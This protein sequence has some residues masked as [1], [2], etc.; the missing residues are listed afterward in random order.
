MRCTICKFKQRSYEYR[1]I[2]T[3][4]LAKIW[5]LVP[6]EI[7]GFNRRE[8]SFCHRC[9]SSLRSR[10]LAEAIMQSYPESKVKYFVD[11]VEW[12]KTKRLTIA[13]INYCGHLHQYLSKI[14]GIKTSQY[15]ESTWRAR[16]ANILKGIGSEDMT[17][18]SYKS[19]SFDLVLHS[20]VVEHIND[21]KKALAECK[22]ILIPGGICLFTT[23]LIIN[24]K[25][26]R[27]AV[28]DEKMKTI[29]YYGTPSYH[30][31]GEEDNLVF[32]EFGGDFIRKNKLKV[33]LAYPEDYTWVL[34]IEK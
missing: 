32:W 17:D 28:I 7:R 24:R 30:G 31:S 22:R 12:A 11:W 1:D 33:A 20:E 25:T 15:R 3:T 26:K 14:P 10:A 5:K 21:T 9:G 2:I 16:L 6:E 29:K 4:D 13:E 19:N 18:L 8:S 27:K 23:P 34:K